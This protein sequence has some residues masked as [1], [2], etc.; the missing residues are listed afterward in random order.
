MTVEDSKKIA[1]QMNIGVFKKLNLD[2]QLYIREQIAEG[3]IDSFS[4]FQQV[5]DEQ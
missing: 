1:H 2:L 3:V 4:Q 5:I